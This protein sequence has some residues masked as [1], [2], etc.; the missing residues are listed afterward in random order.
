MDGRI[1][2]GGRAT[3]EVIVPPEILSYH[4]VEETSI[5]ALWI[6]RDYQINEFADIDTLQAISW[7]LNPNGKAGDNE[8]RK[9]EK[10]GFCWNFPLLGHTA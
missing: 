1:D 10:R 9:N 5:D 2:K 7:A 8:G 6:I 4:E 3:P